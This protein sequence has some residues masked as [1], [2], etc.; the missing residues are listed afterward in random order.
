MP[1]DGYQ[2]LT[3]GR[4]IRCA[5][6]RGPQRP[7]LRLGEASLSY[8]ALVSH[9]ARIAI[10][11]RE[12]F[13]LRPGDRVALIAPNC[14]PYVEI[15]AGLSDIGA[16]VAT[17]T[18]RLT[19]AELRDVLDDCTPRLI[20][21]HPDCLAAIDPNW[22][23][24]L[25]I[26]VIDESYEALI[27]GVGDARA[28]HR[29]DETDP[30]ALA[31]T[32]GTTGRPKGVL[33]SHRSRALTF[34]AMAAEY[35]CFGADDHFLALAPMCHGAGFVFAVAPL[36]FGGT[37]TLFNHSDPEAI[38][39]RLSRRDISGMFVVPTH[40]ARIF[41]LPQ[42]TLDTYHDHRLS[43]IISNAAALPQHLKRR[44]ID[45]FGAG[46]L[47]ET[48]GSTEAGIVTNIR[49]P[50]LIRK[51]DS[52]GL[53]FANMAIE[54]RDESGAIVAT[55]TPG[56]LFCRGPTAFNGYWRRPDET[57]E[58]M[59]DGWVTA[60]DIARR[61]GDGFITIVDRKKDMVVTGG[62]NVYPR[63][64]ENVIGAMEGVREVAVIGDPDPEW[65]EVLH[66]VVVKSADGGPGEARILQACRSRLAGYKVP[67]RT[68]FV[69]ELPRTA[70]G[71]VLKNVLK[72]MFAAIER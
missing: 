22:R 28:A 48:Y 3:I 45:H 72:D 66:A 14:L 18:P 26:Q 62:I 31:Y 6:A 25:A 70:G 55:D 24:E 19:T 35:G 54:L 5:A 17:L 36:F 1:P 12:K 9:M 7:A 43:A 34:L 67:R 41:D 16:I 38:L 32:S 69:S 23:R 50:D 33:L 13:G 68:S 58:A 8:G 57:R 47:H 51:S 53:P 20:I 39:A 11:G 37:T 2:P 27:A 44:V 10:V 56:E 64:I 4:G 60:G 63:E 65:G 49:P 52:V 42:A 61:D 21:V 46:L 40:L 59:V 71:K 30:F 15:V 29:P